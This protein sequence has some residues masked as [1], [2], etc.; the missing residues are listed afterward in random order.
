MDFK[1]FEFDVK[2]KFQLTLE[3]M[4]ILMACS[5]CHYDGRCKFASFKN[6]KDPLAS[7]FLVGWQG[8]MRMNHARP[9]LRP[10]EIVATSR[11]L[12]SCM[13]ILEGA[14]MRFMS[15]PEKVKLAWTLSEALHNMFH[16]IGN[17]SAK[18]NKEEE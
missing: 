7:G 5:E 6:E 15:E 13:K 17:E 18:L 16:W 14:G 9:D 1:G 10:M 8:R 11:E 2:V 4:D 12:D 3:E